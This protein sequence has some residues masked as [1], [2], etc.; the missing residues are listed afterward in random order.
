MAKACASHGSRNTGP[1]SS[2]GMP[3]TAAVAWRAA[4]GSNFGSGGLKV[5]LERLDRYGQRRI[6]M[7]APEVARV[8]HHR[9]KP[10][11]VLALPCRDRVGK[12]MA[13]AHRFDQAFMAA[14]VTRKPRVRRRI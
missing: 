4:A 7:G 13:A 10:L 6:G 5:R 9:V 14:R 2:R 11:R 12:D 1:C 8:E 3:G